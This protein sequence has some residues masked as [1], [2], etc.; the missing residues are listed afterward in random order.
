MAAGRWRVDGCVRSPPPPA[1]AGLE[2][3][4]LLGNRGAKDETRP[5]LLLVV[6]PGLCRPTPR[7]RHTPLQRGVASGAGAG[8]GA[9]CVW[10][11]PKVCFP[12]PRRAAPRVGG[13]AC[14]PAS[15]FAS[16]PLARRNAKV[17]VRPRATHQI[18]RFFTSPAHHVPSYVLYTCKSMKAVQVCDPSVR[19]RKDFSVHK[20]NKIVG[21]F[22][23]Q[24]Y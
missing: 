4:L 13:H 6:W 21:N 5:V 10:S 18:C 17:R 22:G 12:A 3:L 8:A 20:N 14:V 7:R 15:C 24:T 2:A 1:L 9:S 23:M 19:T 16:P 11:A